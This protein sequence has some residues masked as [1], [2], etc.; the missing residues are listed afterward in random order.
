MHP[1]RFFSRI[2]FQI[3]NIIMYCERANSPQTS[4]R[5]F[6]EEIVK[7]GLSYRVL[8]IG[9]SPQTTRCWLFNSDNTLA[10]IG[11]GKGMGLQSEISAKYEA[12]EHHLSTEK[13]GLKQECVPF[14]LEGIEDKL[15]KVNQKA[16]PSYFV[17]NCNRMKK[18]PWIPLQGYS[19]SSIILPYFLA[20]PD[21]INNPF[22]FDDFDYSTLSDIPSNN[23][24]A[25]GTTLEEAMVHAVNELIERDAIS[26]FL[27]STFGRKSPKKIKIISKSSLPPYLNELIEKIECD[28]DEE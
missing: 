19:G 9:N 4:L 16:L 17:K 14:S 28:Y 1:I 15:S 26:C 23:G 20:N 11:N 21:Y 13:S 24:T 8:P 3:K 2:S 18:T 22:P 5:V 10:D 7:L 6:E 27:L 12:L 25:I